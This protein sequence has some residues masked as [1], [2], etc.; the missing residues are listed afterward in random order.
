LVSAYLRNGEKDL[1]RSK[2]ER[3]KHSK[4]QIG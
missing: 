4:F 3:R 2:H 1:P